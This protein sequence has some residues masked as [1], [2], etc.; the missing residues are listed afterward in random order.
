MKTRDVA[1]VGLKILA[2]YVFFQFL[3][4][5]PSGLR[6]FQMSNTFR[7]I[8]GTETAGTREYAVMAGWFVVVGIA[9]LTVSVSAF[10]GADRLARF[11]V[12]DSQD[13][14]TLAGPV[15]DHFRT[16]AFQ[17]LGVYALI[18]WTPSL[19]QTIVRCT[20]YGT[21]S[22]PQSPF[23]LRL[24]D[25]WSALISPLVGALVGLLLIFRARG[26]VSLTRLARPMSVGRVTG[27]SDKGERGST[28]TGGDA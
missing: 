14:V 15:S 17:C 11:F 16:A 7:D 25:G 21:W 27:L 26:L 8:E 19:V 5:L 6:M 12:S 9:Y 23:L 18:T 3:M 13:S 4:M 10:L 28:T 1:A 24:Y 2:V 20:I 22:D